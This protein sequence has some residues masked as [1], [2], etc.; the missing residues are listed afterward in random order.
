MRTAL[1]LLALL[2]FCCTTGFCCANAVPV[3]AVVTDNH[4]VPAQKPKE[5]PMGT[6]VRSEMLC[7][8]IVARPMYPPAAKAA[9]IQGEVVLR[10]TVD[11]HGNV[12]ELTLVSGHPL[13]V[14]GAIEAVK[15]WKYKPYLVNGKPTAVQTT[16]SVNFTLSGG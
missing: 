14:P 10:A 1:S 12:S 11:R 5:K 13:L 15:Q 8:T 16:V 2:T 4:V 7:G 3:E 9:R 6:D